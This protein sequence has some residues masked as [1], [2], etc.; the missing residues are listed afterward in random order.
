MNKRSHLRLVPPVIVAGPASIVPRERTARD[1]LRVRQPRCACEAQGVTCEVVTEYMAPSGPMPKGW[2]WDTQSRRPT[3][4]ATKH[5][6][7]C[8]VWYEDDEDAHGWRAMVRTD[9]GADL[10]CGLFVS[11]DDARKAAERGALR[12]KQGMRP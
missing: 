11:S 1:L 2:R 4:E 7:E 8:V 6:H 9:H 10:Y 12:V 5:G 3:C